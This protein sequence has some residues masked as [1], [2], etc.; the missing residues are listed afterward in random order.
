MVPFG[1]DSALIKCRLITLTQTGAKGTHSR[2]VPLLASIF[3]KLF[4]VS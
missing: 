2:A 1:P 4:L 3:G